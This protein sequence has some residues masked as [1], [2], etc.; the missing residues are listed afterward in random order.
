MSIPEDNETKPSLNESIMF[1]EYGQPFQL[2][3]HNQLGESIYVPVTQA[4]HYVE[5]ID[6]PPLLKDGESIQDGK[7]YTTSPALGIVSLGLMILAFLVIKVLAPL[8][9][10]DIL[11]GTSVLI[12]FGGAIILII[13]M[14][15]SVV[16]IALHR[17][18]SYA[19]FA[20]LLSTVLVLLWVIPI[21]FGAGLLYLMGF[22]F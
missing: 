18:A 3:G 5:G 19:G 15:L 9:D 14:I 16:A 12:G 21:L 11:H 6:S 13:S 4:S 2:S 10:P 22:R 8:G 1:N 20:L 17:G 7:V